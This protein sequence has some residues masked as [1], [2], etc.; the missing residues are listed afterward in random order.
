MSLQDYGYSTSGST[1]TSEIIYL[2]V[3]RLLQKH[4]VPNARVLDLGCGNGYLSNRLTKLGYRVV[5]VDASASGIAVANRAYPGISFV[6][7]TTDAFL[8]SGEPCFDAVVSVEVIEHCPSVSTFCSE[9]AACVRHGGV[10]IVTTPY[11][12]YLKNLLIALLNRHDS[13][14]NPLWEGGHLKFFSVSTLAH[15]LRSAGLQLMATRYV[16]RVPWLAKSMVAFATK[17]D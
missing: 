3:E 4:V 15:A 14:F 2:E 9:L 17:G 5:G 6:C 7:G 13:H 12:G 8:S 16:G 10:A 1:G 11:H